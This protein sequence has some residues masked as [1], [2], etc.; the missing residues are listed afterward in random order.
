MDWF[1]LLAVQGTLESLLQG[2]GA[3]DGVM[4]RGGPGWRAL[5]GAFQGTRANRRGIVRAERAVRD[6]GSSSLLSFSSSTET[7]PQLG[8]NSSQNS[9]WDLSTQPLT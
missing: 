2:P 7:A 8:R 4:M 3:K 1:D 5:G 6:L 9:V